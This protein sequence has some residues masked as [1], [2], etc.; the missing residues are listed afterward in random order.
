[1]EEW[2][3]IKLYT[4]REKESWKSGKMGKPELRFQV[5]SGTV[6]V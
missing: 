5:S 3:Y 4:K 2:T 6:A 1:M